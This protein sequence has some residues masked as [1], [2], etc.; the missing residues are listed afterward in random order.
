[1]AKIIKLIIYTESNH[2]DH[3]NIKYLNKK[4]LKYRTVEEYVY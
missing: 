4:Q 3:V 2:L 1:M